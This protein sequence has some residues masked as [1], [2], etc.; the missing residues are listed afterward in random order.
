MWD[1]H[2]VNNIAW[3]KRDGL[4]KVNGRKGWFLMIEG[5]ICIVGLG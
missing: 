3:Q 4:R 1:G 5:L 2:T